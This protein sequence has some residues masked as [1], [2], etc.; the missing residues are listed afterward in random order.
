M[1][2]YKDI[3]LT[4]EAFKEAIAK[5][6]DYEAGI[7]LQAYIPDSFKYLQDLVEFSK[8]RVENGGKPIKIRFVKGANM[9]AEE[10]FASQRGWLLPAFDK[11]VDTDSNYKKIL[12]YILDNKHYKYINI[13]IASHNIFKIAH[14]YTVISDANALDSFTFEML[15]GMSLQTS[16]ELSKIRKLILYVPVCDKEHFN[17]A[18][19]YL[20]R[21]LDENTSEDNFM[22]YF[23]DLKVG[24][25]NWKLQ[26]EIFLKSFDGIEIIDNTPRKK[27]NRLE[28]ITK[29]NISENNIF[30]NEP[31]TEILF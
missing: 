19:A 16:F 22:R 14:A 28:P 6:L 5:Y 26:K 2:E 25:K 30:V 31:D 29:S 12:Y 23:F 4:S 9:E 13:G 10:T 17:N 3:E 18:I 20:V 27:Q 21:R 1:E 15:E 24:D 7:V 8:Q 11:K